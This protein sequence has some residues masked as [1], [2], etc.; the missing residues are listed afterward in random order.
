MEGNYLPLRQLNAQIKEALLDAFPEFVWV[1]ADISDLRINR[2]GHCYL[3]LVEK[4]EEGDKISA[5]ARGTIWAYTF[6]MLKPYFEQT[7]GYKLESGLK[8]MLECSVEFH[9]IYGLSLNIRDID[10]TYTLGDLA[11]QRAEIIARLKTDGVY[12]MNKELDFPLVPQKVAVIS[13]ET[14]A[15]YGDFINQLQNNSYGYIVYTKLFQ[16]FMQGEATV[17]SITAALENIFE[18]EDKFDVVVIIRGGG[19]KSDLAWFDNY[20][21][22]ANVA[23]F[24]LPVLTGIGHERDETVVDLV[25]CESYKTP[26]A[27]AESIIGSMSQFEAIIDNLSSTLVNE[28]KLKISDEKNRIDRLTIKLV[29]QVNKKLEKSGSDMSLAINRLK[30]ATKSYFSQKREHLHSQPQFLKINIINT[31]KFNQQN[32][33]LAVTKL[34]DKTVKFLNNNN[35]RLT[36]AE[37]RNKMLNPE[38]ILKRGYAI[39][40]QNKRIVK[41]VKE[42]EEGMLIKTY[43]HDG[44]ANS[45]IKEIEHNHQRTLTKEKGEKID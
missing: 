12:S 43:W 29:P 19:S 20:E 17:T 4:E 14:A 11:K 2:N 45:E 38:N 10:P 7:T 42:I 32:I 30:S 36:N 44:Y 25:A 39:V 15:G 31:I 28:I 41:T 3:E 27:V 26:T 18:S 22:A 23:Q 9:E 13:S 40:Y 8:V 34:S 37:T 33:N 21:L 1:V 5:K 6:R 35:Q 16:A 24:P